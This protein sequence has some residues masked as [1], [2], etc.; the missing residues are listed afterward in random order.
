MVSWAE[1]RLRLYLF[2]LRHS[3]YVVGRSHG[4]T[5][6]TRHTSSFQQC[7]AQVSKV[8]FSSAGLDELVGAH[9]G[10]SQRGERF[11]PDPAM[12]QLQAQRRAT[13]KKVYHF[14]KQR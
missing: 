7:S 5:C 8:M 9:I 3:C 1:R 2:G 12:L 14:L 6:A 11:V 10:G 13:A 4:N